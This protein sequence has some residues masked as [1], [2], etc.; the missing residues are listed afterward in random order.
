MIVSMLRNG[1]P[2]SNK[3]NEAR[4]II[5]EMRQLVIDPANAERTS[6]GVFR[7]PDPSDANHISVR[8]VALSIMWYAIG[9]RRDT[10]TYRG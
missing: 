1:S 9:K 10:K 5:R 8:T 7:F 4:L 3:L 6:P 2:D